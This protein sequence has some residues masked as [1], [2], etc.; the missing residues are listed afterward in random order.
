MHRPL[1]DASIPIVRPFGQVPIKL[2]V[3]FNVGGAECPGQGLPTF[4]IWVDNPT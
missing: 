2:D 4:F 3:Q 1:S